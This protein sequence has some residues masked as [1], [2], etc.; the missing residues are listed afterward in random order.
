M[1]QNGKKVW[2]TSDGVARFE[3]LQLM[4]RYAVKSC[5]KILAEGS[6]KWFWFISRAFLESGGGFGNAHAWTQQPYPIFAVTANLTY[7]LGKGVFKGK[8]AHLPENS[9]GYLFDRGEEDVAI[10]FAN[11]NQSVTIKSERV[12]VSD[13]FGKEIHLVAKNGEVS[14]E[15]SDDPIFVR[16]SDRADVKDYFES[17]FSLLECEKISLPEEKRIVL[18]PV[19]ENQDLSKA[20]I[21]QKGYIFKESDCQNVTLRIYNLNDVEM[22]GR[23]YVTAE[24]TSHF[25]IDIKAPDFCIEPF[26]R[27]DIDIAIKTTGKA[28]MNSMGDMLFGATLSDGR[29]VSSAVC[30]Y[31][32]KLDDMD[33]PGEDIKVFEG[34]CEKENWNRKNIMWPGSMTFVRNGNEIT[35][36]ADHGEG[37]AQWYFPEFFVKDASVFE[38]TDGLI[39]KRKH[40][41]STNTKLTAFICTND[42]RAYWSGDASGV[43]YT[44]D[45]RTIVYPWDTFVLFSSPEGLNDPRPFDPTKIYKVRIGASGTPKGFIPDT[46]IRDFGVFYDNTGAT[47]PHPYSI[48]FEGVEEGATYESAEGLCLTATLPP[49]CVGDIRVFVGKTAWSNYK[50]EGNKVYVDLSHLGRGEYTLQVSCKTRVNYRYSRYV[51]FYI[52]K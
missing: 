16:F 29:E 47:K 12:T 46:T 25:D 21:M 28:K 50:V 30:R 6:D 33:I 7:Q 2:T 18:N 5:A 1:T 8:L 9:Y 23:A 39:L 17:S 14:V 42:G 20:I 15:I 45:W 52:E 3:Q 27:V 43:A 36:K 19:W 24:Y 48:G 51:T 13:M 34:F 22:R 37:H 44:D 49:D 11:G 35:L 31:W 32:F 40:S 10:I 4:C 26:G 38:G 41:H